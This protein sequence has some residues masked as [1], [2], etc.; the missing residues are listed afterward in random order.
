MTKPR[1]VAGSGVDNKR[2][3]LPFNQTWDWHW[4]KKATSGRVAPWG[5][6]KCRLYDISIS[7]ISWDWQLTTFKSVIVQ[8]LKEN[9]KWNC[10]Q[11]SL[12][13]R[14]SNEISVR[15]IGFTRGGDLG[16]TGG[17]FPPKCEVG[18]GPCIGPPIFR[19]VVL[20]DAR[21]STWDYKNE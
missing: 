7:S 17:T 8:T 1:Q 12:L 19:E 21:E 9:C 20:S 2:G 13:K 14:F 11:H 15:S 3:T 16:G 10:L 4:G 6:Q 18:D 5:Q